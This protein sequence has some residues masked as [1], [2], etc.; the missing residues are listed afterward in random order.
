MERQNTGNRKSFAQAVHGKG[1]RFLGA[2]LA[3][4]SAGAV[5]AGGLSQEPVANASPEQAQSTEQQVQAGIADGLREGAIVSNA[6][7]VTSIPGSIKHNYTLVSLQTNM[8][9]ERL[10]RN[11][12]TVPLATQKGGG[13]FTVVC[14][15]WYRVP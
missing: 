7:S 14:G 1:I 3:V 9:P 10:V 12:K 5:F 13:A 11:C 15:P 6:A 4:L 8:A 2:S